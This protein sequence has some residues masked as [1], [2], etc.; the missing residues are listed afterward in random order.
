MPDA[1]LLQADPHEFIEALACHVHQAQHL[2]AEASRDL[3]V[4][5]QLH[6]QDPVTPHHVIVIQKHG[7]YITGTPCNKRKIMPHN[8][9]PMAIPRPIHLILLTFTSSTSF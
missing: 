9:I 7:I 1:A 8:A 2:L 3:M 5:A 4:G 6:A